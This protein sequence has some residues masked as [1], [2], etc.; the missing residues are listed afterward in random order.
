MVNK[1]TKIERGD[2]CSGNQ[3]YE[4]KI[5]WILLDI[6]PKFPF[7]VNNWGAVMVVSKANPS[8][9]VNRRDICHKHHKQRLCKIISTGVKFHF[10]TVLLKQF[11]YVCTYFLVIFSHINH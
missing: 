2:F 9:S 8:A 4:G 11:M 6:L 10:V 5:F 7:K 1:Y 3:N